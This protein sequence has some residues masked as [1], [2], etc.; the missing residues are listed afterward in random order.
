MR[1][2]NETDSTEH[3]LHDSDPI[4]ASL[5]IVVFPSAQTEQATWIVPGWEWAWVKG[6][7]T[8]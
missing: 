1:R 4:P 6:E 2:G 7:Q 8:T 3:H 5:A